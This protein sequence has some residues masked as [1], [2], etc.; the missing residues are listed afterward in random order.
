MLPITDVEEAFECVES[1]AGKLARVGD[2][3]VN[4]HLFL[5]VEARGDQNG[6][7]PGI[8][9]NAICAE[10]RAFQRVLMPELVA[11]GNEIGRGGGRHGAVD[12]K[13]L[14]QQRRGDGL[15]LGGGECAVQEQAL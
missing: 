15:R 12:L 2:E 6:V 8:R 10:A 9:C 5:F 4:Q 1:I 11:G 13:E 3:I 7:Q 14:L